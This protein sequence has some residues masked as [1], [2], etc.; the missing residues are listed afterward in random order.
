MLFRDAVPADA[1]G[2]A[3]VHVRAWQV[4]YRGL[5]SD[6]YLDDL[7]PEDRAAR[8]ALGGAD[9]KRP[10]TIVAVDDDGAIRGFATTGP[11]REGAEAGEL[12][13]LYVDPDFWGR[14][15]GRTLVSAGRARLVGQGHRQAVLWVLEGNARADRFY[16]ADGWSPDGARRTET[17]WG[18][19]ATDLRYLRS[20][21]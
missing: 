4:G 20:L 3:R 9:P 12:L 13:A 11:D 6:A 2:V 21:P 16:R 15:V 17:I 19:A 1:L 8:Y 10:A 7:R 5:L 14:G 18:V